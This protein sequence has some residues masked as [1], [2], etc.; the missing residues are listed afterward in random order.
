MNLNTWLFIDENAQEKVN[1][2][3]AIFVKPQ[4]EEQFFADLAS[5]RIIRRNGV[6]QQDGWWRSTR[7]QQNRQTYGAKWAPPDWMQ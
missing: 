2:M 7:L 4:C 3:A 5:Y 6:F 1:S